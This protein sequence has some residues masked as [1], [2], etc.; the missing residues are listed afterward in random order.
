MAIEEN[1][2]HPLHKALHESALVD[3]AVVRQMTRFKSM[4]P[5]YKRVKDGTFPPPIRLSRR[6]SRWRL[7]DIVAWCEAQGP[8]A[9][10]A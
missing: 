2:R 3:G 5:I 6:C 1:E 4:T 8:E 7:R 10:P 9:R